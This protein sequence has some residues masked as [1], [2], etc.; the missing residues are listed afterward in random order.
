MNYTTDPRLDETRYEESALERGHLDGGRLDG[1]REDKTPGVY[2]RNHDIAPSHELD[3]LWSGNRTHHMR[4]ERS[5]IIAFVFGLVVGALLTAAVAFFFFIKPEIKTGESTMTTSAV[6]EAAS[7]QPHVTHVVTPLE[8]SSSSG[9]AEASATSTATSIKTAPPSTI[10]ESKYTVKS[11]D[12]M[13]SIARHHY[14]AGTPNFIEKIRRANGI[15]NVN[16]LKLDQE[17]VIPPKSY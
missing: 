1:G 17:L 3:L 2:V 7:T 9:Q 11:G 5:P 4:D 13:E 15:K 12:T 8:P 14:G 16:S 6:N 10:G